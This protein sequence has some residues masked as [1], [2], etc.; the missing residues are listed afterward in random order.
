MRYGTLYFLDA[1]ALVKVFIRER[2]SF[3]LRAVLA[4]EQPFYTTS[5]CFGEA[6][7]VMKRK[8]FLEKPARLTQDE[9]ENAINFLRSY[10]KDNVIKLDDEPS[11]LTNFHVFSEAADLSRKYQVDISDALQLV[12]LLRCG[13]IGVTLV[14]A[15]RKLAEAARTEKISVWNCEDDP[16]PQ[17]EI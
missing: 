7:G 4:K 2:G 8:R 13:I 3:Q 16:P 11:N 10:V 12:W 15:D 14:T 1:S 6:L 5:L 9:Y 17:T